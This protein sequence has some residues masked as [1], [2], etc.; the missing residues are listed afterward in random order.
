MDSRVKLEQ[1]VSMSCELMIDT[2]SNLGLL[3][4]TTEMNKFSLRTNRTVVGFG[5]NGEVLGYQ[6]RSESVL[7]DGLSMQNI[8]TGII[9]S[10]WHNYASIG[11]DILKHYVVVINYYKLYASFKKLPARA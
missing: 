10:P 4:K 6:T 11:M 2:G 7:L 5:F 1:E 8:P 9:E 3:L